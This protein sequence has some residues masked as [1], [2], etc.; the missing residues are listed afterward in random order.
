[1]NTKR[2]LIAFSLVTV[3]L[4][5]PA[6]ARRVAG[7]DIPEILESAGV[8]LILNGVGTRTRY[9][10]DVY[11]G[12]LYLQ[13]RSTDAAAIMEAD[14]Q[15]AIKLWVVTGLITSDRMQKSIE[16]GFQRSTRGN[17]APF[18]EKIDLLMGLYDDEINDEDTFEFV[19]S[20][21]QGLG[22]YKNGVYREVIDCG[23]PFK[24]A[25]FGIWLSDRPVQKSLKHSLLGR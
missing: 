9:L 5:L 14:E 19:Y 7:M 21:G 13:K 23:L 3:L 4:A 2:L 15:M 10:L 17:T 24:R 11:V 12:G 6:D 20:P 8:P 18:R 16:D 22:V 25:F 1:M